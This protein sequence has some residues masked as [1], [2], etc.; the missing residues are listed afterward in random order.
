MWR[1]FSIVLLF[2]T[3]I[4]SACWPS[5]SD[6]RLE[7]I[8]QE[9]MK[10]GHAMV[11]RDYQTLAGYTYPKMAEKMGGIDK[12]IRNM[13]EGGAYASSKGL[14]ID[15]VEIGVPEPI[16]E[17]SG[18]LYSLVL[19]TVY[20]TTSKGQTIMKKYLLAISED[21]GNKW[22]FIDA[23]LLANEEYMKEFFPDLVGKI[24]IPETQEP[25]RIPNQ[26]AN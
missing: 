20:M 13:S 15:N 12:M 7:T 1:S 10:K 16:I 8:R 14:S 9:G 24:R 25:V 5:Y 6:D 3:F 26:Q 11:Y 4:F 18:N 23:S 19:E 17:V 22:Y 2:L 21:Q